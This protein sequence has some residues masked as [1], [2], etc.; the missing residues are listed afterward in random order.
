[1]AKNWKAYIGETDFK[2]WLPEVDVIEKGE[3]EKEAFNSRQIFGVMS[4]S[5]KDRQGEN[6][7]AKGLEISQFLKN[8][9]FNDNHSQETSAIIGYPEEAFYKS[10][11]ILDDG[12]LTD[13]YVCRGYILKGTKRADGIWE[14]AKALQDTPK[15][16]GFSIEGKVE[17][18]QNK[19][20]EKAII[21]NVAITN[22]PVNADA[23]WEV[24]EKSFYNE[25][26][27]MKSLSA[28]YA[29]SGQTGG[30]ALA[31]ESLDSNVKD[32]KR[33]EDKKKKKQREALE[34]S[35]GIDDMLKSMD[36]L[37]DMRPQYDE[38]TAAR[39]IIAMQRGLFNNR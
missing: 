33:D 7:L 16:L 27:A 37:L 5:R 23:T 10:D 18:R 14:L 29:T 25:E 1:M 17:R 24:M 3:E 19:I 32:V 2:I 26:M 4:T 39:I 15:K 22:C 35:L 21:R 31:S 34:R 20:I 38:E 28:G 36:I 13:G 8:G 11:I 30:G 6:V 12:T 9:H